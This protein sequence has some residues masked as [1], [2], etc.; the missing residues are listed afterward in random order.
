MTFCQSWQNSEGIFVFR[1]SSLPGHESSSKCPVCLLRSFSCSAAGVNIHY[2]CESLP[3]CLCPGSWPN[4]VMVGVLSTFIIS[5]YIATGLFGFCLVFVCFL[6]FLL[7]GPLYSIA[8]AVVN[9]LCSSPGSPGICYVDQSGLELAEILPSAERKGRQ[10]LP[11]PA[12]LFFV[13]ETCF[14][15]V[16]LL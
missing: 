5:K 11:H 8:L 7:S 1:V 4:S 2:F 6:L 13:R 15:H 12:D 10:M 3:E 9:L 16:H 14:L